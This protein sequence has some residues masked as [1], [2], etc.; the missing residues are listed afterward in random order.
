ME[1][2]IGLG[3]FIIGIIAI[4][5]ASSISIILYYKTKI[6]N[7][8]EEYNEKLERNELKNIRCKVY[9]EYLDSFEIAQ[10]KITVLLEDFIT[11]DNKEGRLLTFSKDIMNTYKMIKNNKMRLNASP[12]TYLIIN[13]ISSV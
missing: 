6:N 2:V 7:L 5:L 11:S 8:K 3:T 4:I 9:N 10:D 1:I 13:E 12:Q